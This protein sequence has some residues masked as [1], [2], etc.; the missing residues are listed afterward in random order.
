MGFFVYILRSE[1]GGGYYVGQTADVA[2][3]L[4]RH[5]A[6]SESATA[7]YVP[8]TLI[9]QAEK[10]TRSEA[11]QLERK[12]KNLSRVRLEAFMRKYGDG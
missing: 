9:W 1:S 7:R 5:N 10:P 12:L 2:S 11:V 4:M 3:R 6:G 8:W